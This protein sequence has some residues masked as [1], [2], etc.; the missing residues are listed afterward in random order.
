MSGGP[1][2]ACCSGAGR[3]IAASRAAVA[4]GTTSPGAFGGSGGSTTAPRAVAGSTGA[5]SRIGAPAR[6]GVRRIAGPA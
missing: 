3:G 1:Y 5:A 6:F 4:V 2:E